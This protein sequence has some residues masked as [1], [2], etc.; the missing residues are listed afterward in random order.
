MEEKRKI[1]QIP[2]YDEDGRIEYYKIPNYKKHENFLT[3]N[4]II[5][6]R[7]LLLTI[8]KYN[9]ENKNKSYLVVFSQVAI[10]RIIDINNSRNCKNLT[11]ELKNKSIDFVIYDIK[12]ND[13]KCCIELDGPEHE[14]DIERKKRD[15]LLDK[16]FKDLIKIIHIK[17]REI[18]NK[19]EL[20]RILKEVV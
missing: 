11:E 12:N 2:V 4:E 20:E 10:N 14:I 13:I 19:E 3:K 1:E 6:F 15:I 8:K 9:K 5:F 18:Y 7:E 16:M 17:N